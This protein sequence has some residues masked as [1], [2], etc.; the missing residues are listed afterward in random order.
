MRAFENCRNAGVDF[1][2]QMLV[3]CCQIIKLHMSRLPF[4]R[5]AIRALLISAPAFRTD[6]LLCQTFSALTRPAAL[7]RRISHHNRMIRDIFC[8]DAA[9]CNKR[10]SADPVT[11]DNCRVGPNARALSHRRRLIEL[12]A[13]LRVF[14]ARTLYIGKH[15][16]GSAE[17]VIA[18]L[19][20][21]IDAHIVL[22]FAVTADRHTRGYKDILSKVA[23]FSD[24][25]AGTDVR[26]VPDFRSRPN[27]CTVINTSA[28]VDKK[29]FLL[30]HFRVKSFRNG[31]SLPLI[32][33]KDLESYTDI[34]YP[35]G[36]L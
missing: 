31:F 21:V 28:W 3:L 25:R 34:L 7:P 30:F 29:A 16:R 1:L 4:F 27:A 22:N 14:A 10:M 19:Y 15:H 9:R 20:T 26:K 35:D 12:M 5:K 23:A 33:G 2:L 36:E 32:G 24:R 6:E 17:H 8:Y 11:A 13:R 18:E